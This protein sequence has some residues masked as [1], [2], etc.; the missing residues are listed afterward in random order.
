MKTLHRRCAGLDV[1][2]DTVVACARL[3]ARTKASH[4]VRRFS[5]ATH[6]LLELADW[7]A[8]QGVTHVAM[9]ATGIYWKPIWHMLE[10]RFVLVL[11]N[12]AH[13]RNVPGRKSDVN[14]AVWISDLLAHGLIRASFV[15]PALIQELRD[16]T[17]TRTQLTRELARHVQRIQKT[18]EDANIKLVSVISDIVGVSGRRILKA[19]IAGETNAKRLTE[20][21][22]TRLKC[23]RSDLA[24]ALDG[25]V[26]VHHRFLID[27]HLGLVEELERRI[28]AF[29]ARIEEVLAPFR[30]IVG[31]LIT[32]PGVGRVAA[33]VI[34]AE[35]G[36]DM[37]PFPTAGHLLSWA[38]VVPRLDESAGKR[39]STRVRHGAPWLKPVL[40]QC[41]WGAAR[42]KRTYLQAQFFRLKARR[43]AEK[44]GHRRGGLNPHGC[45][46]H[47][48]RWHFL[49]GSR[50][51]LSRQARC[52]QDCCQA[53]PSH[54]RPRLRRAVSSNRLAI[55][56]MP[57]T[58]G[59]GM[60]ARSSCASIYC[61][62]SALTVCQSSFNSA[63]TSLI[64]ADRQ[65]RPT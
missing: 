32:T 18:L 41:A 9:G 11:A 50:R 34:L 20:L 10:G 48:E 3:T 7:L 60:P 33:E 31:R 17:R 65:R 55:S 51:R 58:C 28:A 44:S 54:Q 13:I 1:H 61:W 43:G 53:R 21:G 56:S 2:S 35:I 36:P 6:D 30:D 42:A 12:A 46:P 29:D 16:L 19:M 4:E 45:L 14:D 63:A 25:R 52:G 15:P 27:H 23:S 26:T 57:I 40:V 47:A 24:A 5:T 38:G 49:S 39:H 22:S 59:E 37:S 64:V 62:S 8:G